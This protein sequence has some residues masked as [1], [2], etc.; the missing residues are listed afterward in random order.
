MQTIE[1][2]CS[3]ALTCICCRKPLDTNSCIKNEDNIWPDVVDVSPTP[4]NLNFKQ[5]AFIRENHGKS[6]FGVAFNSDNR[7]R[8]TDPLLFA[9]VGGNHVTIYQCKNLSMPAE[10]S[11]EG[12]PVI[13]LQSFADPAG[14]DEDFYC[15]AWSRNLDS[16]STSD[17]CS[18]SASSQQQILAVS[19]KRGIIRLLCP[20]LA[21]C[22]ASLVG[23][24]QSVNELKPY[25]TLLQHFPEFSSR[26]A[27]GNYVDCARWFGSLVISK[28][29]ENAVVVWKPGPLDAGLTLP[30]RLT[31]ID[32]RARG[33][34]TGV[35]QE[36]RCSVL[37]QLRLPDCQLWYIR[38]DL[39]LAHRLLALGTGV[40]L[41]RIFLWDL[42]QLESAFNLTPK[43]LQ[44]SATGLGGVNNFGAIR[45]TRFANDGRTLIAVGD[46]GLVVRFDKVETDE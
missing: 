6:I 33:D 37:H 29:C 22:L 46:G 19:G 7:S 24:G 42:S 36:T 43:I 41:P 38:F 2:I 40:G 26:D 44:V 4:T 8:P 1:F 18:D 30:P 32:K 35:P 45:Q 34:M 5:T 25:P 15:C 11:I 20:S 16:L 14:D 12:P 9:T 21:S 28:S 39:D 17:V 27:H 23:H 13:L 10:G 3:L 31:A